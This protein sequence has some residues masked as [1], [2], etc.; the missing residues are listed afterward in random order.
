MRSF[1]APLP[2]LGTPG[3]P[4]PSQPLLHLEKRLEESLG[5]NTAFHQGCKWERAEGSHPPSHS[6]A[7]HGVLCPQHISSCCKWL[8][9]YFSPSF[10]CPPSLPPS[11]NKDR[12]RDKSLRATAASEH[13]VVMPQK[14]NGGRKGHRVSPSPP[15]PPRHGTQPCTQRSRAVCLVTVLLCLFLAGDARGIS[16]QDVRSEPLSGNPM[17]S[18]CKQPHSVAASTERPRLIQRG[19]QV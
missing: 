15:P 17:F 13:H 12:N 2:F 14:H 7:I 3:A 16:L 6:N 19:C 1:P 4:P 18:N 10:V 9:L 5:S 8:Y 11:T